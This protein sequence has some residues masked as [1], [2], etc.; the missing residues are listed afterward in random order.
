MWR[1]KRVRIGVAVLAALALIPLGW[2]GLQVKK[3]MAQDPQ[4]CL[5]CHQMDGP[6]Q[7]WKQSAHAAVTC[8]TCHPGSLASDLRHGWLGLVMQQ[9]QVEAR[10]EVDEQACRSCHVEGEAGD[11]PAIAATVGHRVHVDGQQVPCVDCHG[12]ALHVERPG[13]QLC[14]GC[15][16]EQLAL[17]GMTGKVHCLGCHPYLADTEP[18]VPQASTCRTC[19]VDTAN[20]AEADCLTCHAPHAE[21]GPPDCI[22]CHQPREAGH[23][24]S[25]SCSSCHAPH[26]HA[27]T[28]TSRCA[29]CHRRPAHGGHLACD[30]CH[31]SHEDTAPPACASCHQQRRGLHTNAGHQ[32]CESCHRTHRLT[33]PGPAQCQACHAEVFGSHASKGCSSCHRFVD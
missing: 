5:S 1:S 31:S 6:H 19:H 23:P 9:E 16:D 33:Q 17:V 27:S 2:G 18:L 14:A 22:T 30:A 15:H 20:H 3:A 8:V 28:A 26:Q 13:N 10:A 32:A 12:G 25:A 11:W 24:E 7:R 29:D 21:A 4:F